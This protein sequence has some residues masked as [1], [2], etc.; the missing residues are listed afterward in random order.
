M[1]HAA[2]AEDRQVKPRE[3]DAAARLLQRRVALDC[4]AL[5]DLRNALSKRQPVSEVAP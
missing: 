5:A 3:H 1:S 2:V 4:L